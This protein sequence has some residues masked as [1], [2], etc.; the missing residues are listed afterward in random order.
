MRALGGAQRGLS[1][2]G[3]PDPGVSVLVIRWCAAAEARQAFSMRARQFRCDVDVV[4][5]R[6]RQTLAELASIRTASSEI[7][8]CLQK[9]ATRP[10]PSRATWSGIA[11]GQALAPCTEPSAARGSTP[12]SAPKARWAR[13]V[14]ATGWRMTLPVAAAPVSCNEQA[15]ALW[16]FWF[17]ELTEIYR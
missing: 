3:H 9:L 13:A 10:V 15:D 7:L 14:L 1:R 4:P 2:P 16:T 17:G 6:C 11:M 8:E 12:V 5:A